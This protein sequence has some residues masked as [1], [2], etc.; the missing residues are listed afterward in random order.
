[1]IL[2]TDILIDLVR[3]HPAATT[4]FATL[5]LMPSVSGIAAL[6]LTFGCLNARELRAVTNVSHSIP[7]RL[8][9]G[10]GSSARLGRL[11][12]LHLSHGLSVMDALIA[13]TAVG[14]GL[15][16]VTLNIRHFQAVP[17]LQIVRPYR[18]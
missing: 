12:P 18:R 6:E 11:P 5:S 14:Q 17:G 7:D 2:D 3:Q 10:T 4:W 8:A 13:V 15:T 1:M 16:L 9:L